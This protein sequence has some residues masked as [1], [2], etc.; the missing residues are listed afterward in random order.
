MYPDL[1]KAYDLSQNLSWI[2]ENTK[3][4]TVGLTRL[5]HWYEKVRQSGFKPLTQSLEPCQYIIKE[6]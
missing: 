4:K 1:K 2:F 3:D 5:A 6:Y